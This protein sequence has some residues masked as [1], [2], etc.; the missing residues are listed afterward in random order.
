MEKL[1]LLLVIQS[2]V[3]A[4][5][6]DGIPQNLPAGRRRA[7]DHVNRQQRAFLQVNW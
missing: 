3:V 4:L 6:L 7:L 2:H 1:I 5:H